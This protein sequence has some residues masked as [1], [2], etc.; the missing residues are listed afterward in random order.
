MASDAIKLTKYSEA[1]VRCFGFMAVAISIV[2]VY[3]A[4][5]VA[6]AAGY[7]SFEDAQVL[8]A[9]WAMCMCTMH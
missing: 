4:V 6:A 9:G 2:L 7:A 5:I 8:G 1:A 3:I